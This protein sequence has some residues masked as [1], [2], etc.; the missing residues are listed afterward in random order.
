[1]HK[2]T[3]VAPGSNS[4]YTPMYA[5]V[6]IKSTFEIGDPNFNSNSQCFNYLNV[7]VFPKS[8]CSLDLFHIFNTHTLQ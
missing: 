6:R 3:K 1:M 7:T 8:V 4:L 5:F 2:G